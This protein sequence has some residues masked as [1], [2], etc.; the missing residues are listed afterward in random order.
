[1][2]TK[3]ETSGAGRDLNNENNSGIGK[4]IDGMLLN[5]KQGN[6]PS[7]ETVEKL[8]KALSDGRVSEEHKNLIKKLI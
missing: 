8:T 1:M 3:K 6:K 4:L 7:E 5:A 2:I